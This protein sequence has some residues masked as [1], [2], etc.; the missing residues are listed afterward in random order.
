M[1]R[2]SSL[3]NLGRRSKWVTIRF[4]L[5]RNGL[6]I[7]AL[8][9]T[10][11]FSH[12]SFL[13]TTFVNLTLIFFLDIFAYKD[14]VSPKLSHTNVQA[15]N[16]LLRSE[17][18]VSKDGQLQTAPLIL[19]YELLS[20]TFQDVGQAIRAGSS[21]LARIDVSKPRFLAQ[22]DLPP[23]MRPILQNPLPVAL[24]LPQALPV[25]VTI[26]AEGV[27]SSR[28][29]LDEE[30]DKF[31]FEEEQ[32]P[33]APL[34]CISDTEG[35]SDRSSGVH[36]PYLTLARPDDLDEEEDSMT[37]NKGN[38]SLRGLLAI[39]GKESTSKTAHTSQVAH[40]PP[41]QIP[42]DLSLKANPDLKKKR[43]V[44][45]LEEGKVGPQKG[46]KQ[47]KMALEARSK[48]SQFVESREEQHRANVR[49][50]QRI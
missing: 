19:D 24:P 40:P 42:L 41:P 43:P 11:I 1:D 17:I 50:T 39:R 44:V 29:S 37:L 20:H 13:A 10:H 28:L 18:F 7:S 27:A 48:R 47:Q 15:L 8:T 23:V 46:T 2:R 36:N 30:I 6:S 5:F 14:H 26:P 16:Y 9:Y 34:I 22:K 49:I 4:S 38:R 33:R 45:T 25:V 12:H 31:Y 32:S 21:R 3:S 35:E